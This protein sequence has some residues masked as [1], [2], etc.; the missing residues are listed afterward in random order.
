SVNPGKTFVGKVTYIA[1]SVDRN[2][3]YQVEVKI[4]AKDNAGLRAG[5]YVTAQLK[6]DT[7]ESVLQIPKRAL[8]EGVKNAY[9][10]VQNGNRA[11]RKDIHVG[12]ENGEYI[13]V[14]HGLEEGEKVVVDG[15]INIVDNSLIQ[16]Q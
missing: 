4:P 6:T 10:F 7:E 13:E 12:R 3:N 1:P 14:I 11:E 2:Y 16:A 8:V 5:T 9:V 15:Q